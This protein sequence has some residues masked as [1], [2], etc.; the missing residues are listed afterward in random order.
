MVA[1]HP[2]PAAAEHH[3]ALH[4]RAPSRGMGVLCRSC[5]PRR[6]S[7]PRNS[8]DNLA[9]YLRRQPLTDLLSLD[10]LYWMVL[11]VP[12]KTA[13][14]ARPPPVA[15]GCSATYDRVAEVQQEVPFGDTDLTII[16][17]FD[18]N[19][20]LRGTEFACVGHLVWRPTSGS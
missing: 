20:F 10:A 1:G 7:R 8:V 16:L 14:A 9:F 4:V 2:P 13:R 17:D 18:W 6:P 12:T 19:G 3:A 11:D 5:W 15:T